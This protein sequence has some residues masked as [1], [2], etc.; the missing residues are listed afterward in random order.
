MSAQKPQAARA[1]KDPEAL[2]EKLLADP[3]SQ[4]LAQH[5]GVPL[6]E[7]VDQVLHYVLHP[8]E[9]PSLYLL[10]DKDLRAMGLEPPDP[11]VMGHFLME[12]STQLA[13]EAQTELV[14]AQ[15]LEAERQK[16]LRA[17]RH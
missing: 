16:R 13:A 14:D 10:E 8:K 7:Y 9:A 6:T 4:Q 5:L 3:L 11:E 12:A 2:R 15:R 1:V 17:S